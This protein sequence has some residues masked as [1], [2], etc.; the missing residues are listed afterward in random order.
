M[1]T[2]HTEISIEEMLKDA[3]PCE[4]PDPHCDSNHTQPATWIGTHPTPTGSCSQLMCQAC[5]DQFEKDRA[6]ARILM[7]IFPIGA[8]SASCHKCK[9]TIEDTNTITLRR[10]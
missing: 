3:I 8:V 6:K 2:T 1:T 7:M 5:V 9:N 4:T 10:I